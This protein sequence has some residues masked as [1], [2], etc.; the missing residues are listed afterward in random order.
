VE[1]LERA[2]NDSR[3]V[4]AEFIL[5][6]FRNTNRL[7]RSNF[8]LNQVRYHS[9]FNPEW[10]RIE[11]YAVAT[12]DQEIFFPT[13]DTGFRWEKNEQILVEISRKFEPARLQEQLRFFGV[14]PVAH[15]TDPQEWFSVLLFKKS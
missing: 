10:R 3:G 9:W 4:T 14:T 6:V 13:A 11:M 5:N 8:D 12:Q 7:L 2:Y 1:I 15:F